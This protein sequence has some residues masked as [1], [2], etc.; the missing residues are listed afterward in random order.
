MHRSY[1][2]RGRLLGEPLVA[3]L[4]AVSQ[5]REEAQISQNRVLERREGHG[6]TLVCEVRGLGM[7][8]G[9]CDLL[10]DLN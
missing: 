6:R 1:G 10:N 9:R 3:A 7:D 5:R 8:W 2:P 4:P